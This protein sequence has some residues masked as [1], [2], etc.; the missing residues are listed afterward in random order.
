ME[1]VL[2]LSE[3]DVINYLGDCGQECND[4]QCDDCVDGD[5]CSDD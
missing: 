3:T 1:T 4:C 2:V 5:C